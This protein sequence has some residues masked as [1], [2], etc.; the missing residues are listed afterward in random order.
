M[1]RETFAHSPDF[2]TRKLYLLIIKETYLYF[3]RP[4]LYYL[5]QFAIYELTI[6]K[7]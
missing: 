5:P 6:F 4:L 3:F 2:S 1:L 7:Q